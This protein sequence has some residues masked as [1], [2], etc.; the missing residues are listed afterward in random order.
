MHSGDMSIPK[1]MYVF[2]NM[3]GTVKEQMFHNRCTLHDITEMGQDN[4]CNEVT[5]LLGF[6][7]LFVYHISNVYSFGCRISYL[8]QKL[9]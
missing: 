7:P 6:F 9:Q 8:H 3:Q 1:S 2:R 4:I 5:Y